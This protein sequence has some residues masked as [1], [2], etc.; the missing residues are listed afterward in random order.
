MEINKISV[1]GGIG[2]D[3]QAE[4]VA[5]F[6]LKMGD[7]ISIVGPT[8]CGKTTLINDI[9]LFA[10][11]N[12]P[13][14]RRI[15]INDEPIPED[16]SFDPS[17][18]PIA[19]ISQ[20]TNFLSDLPVGEFLNIH[21]KIRGSKNVLQMIEETL[22]FAN[23]LTGEAII[24]E[25]AMTELSGGQTRSLLIADAVI[26]GHSPIILLDEIENAG[27][28]RTKALKLLKSYKKIFVFVT[29]DPRISLLS[30]FRI[31]MKNGAMQK[32]IVTN[33]EEKMAAL[34]LKKIDDV[35]LEFRK[36]IRA[37]EVITDNVFSEQIK[38]LANS[39]QIYLKRK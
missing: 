33:A 6:D 2:K 9:E 21:A 23:Q 16:F 27:I 22:D 7:I 4:Q 12:T 38:D 14:Q 13:S 20:H 19:L 35:M 28:H 32:M 29:H 11:N 26:I 3:G 17:K 30:D 31:I 10:N 8:G 1:I 34:G 36:L 15:L 37:G 18:H 5:R 24:K 25:T 39:Y